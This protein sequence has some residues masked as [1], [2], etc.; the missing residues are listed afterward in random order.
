MQDLTKALSTAEPPPSSHLVGETLHTEIWRSEMRS[1]LLGPAGD[2]V[3]TQRELTGE[4]CALSF[5]PQQLGFYTLGTPKPAYVFAVNPAT[6]QSDLRPMD[7]NLLPTEF[8]DQHEA[9]LVAGGDDY[10]ELAQGH[11]IFQWFLLSALAVIL[12]ESAFQL[13]VRRKP[14]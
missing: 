12:V 8:S 11:P 10:A 9:H 1:D 14:A 13:L 3:T 2:A 7:K 6:D 5:T 4:R